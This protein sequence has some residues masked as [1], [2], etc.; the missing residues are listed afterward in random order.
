M[1]KFI[2]AI[3]LIISTIGHCQ[4]CSTSNQECGGVAQLKCCLGH[5]L[6]CVYETPIH[7]EARGSCQ[8]T[9][10]K[11]GGICGGFT[12]DPQVCCGGLT[13]TAENPRIP[14]LPGKCQP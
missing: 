1:F 11:E 9:C 7:P 10:S 13:C 5:Q 12:R 8:K 6:T 2:V 4:E 14:D 3:I